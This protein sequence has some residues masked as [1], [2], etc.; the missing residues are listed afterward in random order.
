[1][2]LFRS[3]KFLNFNT[4]ALL[5]IFGNYYPT[6]DL[7]GLKYSSCKLQVNC[8]NNFLSIFNTPRIRFD[9][10]KIFEKFLIFRVN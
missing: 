7:L 3:K 10:T 1:M 9:V 4:I 5:F 8:V 2:D 6:I